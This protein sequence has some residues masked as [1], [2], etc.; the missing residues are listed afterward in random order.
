VKFIAC[1]IAVAFLFSG[2]LATVGSTPQ[3]PETL[4]G[5]VADAGP[6]QTAMVG[7]TVQFDGTGSY[8][9][10]APTLKPQ[11]YAVDI[12]GDGNYLAIG[13]GT[14]VSFFATSSC[15]P[16]WTHDT[17][18][19]VVWVILSEDGSFLATAQNDAPE[20]T[21]SS[22][23]YVS[24]F[25]TSTSQPMWTYQ[26]DYPISVAGRRSLDMTRDGSRIAVGT[27]LRLPSPDY[28][29]K[30]G[31]VY[32]F[33]KDSSTP[34][35]I[36][37]FPKSVMAVRMSGDGNYFA[38][39]SYW[40]E[41]RFYSVTTG[42]LWTKTS[43][44]PFYSV[45]VDYDASYVSAAQGNSK[46]THL[47]RND[48]SLVWTATS[49]G[50]AIGMEMSDDG[51]YF[52]TSE[53]ANGAYRLFG[54]SSPTPAWTYP[55][56]EFV[57]TRADISKDGN[58][59][60]GGSSI[61]T[62]N[63]YLFSKTSG[64]PLLIHPADAGI[65]DVSISY[66]GRCFA[67]ATQGGTLSLFTTEGSP[68]LVWQWT[69]EQPVSGYEL[70]YAWNFGDGATATGTM[71]THA[72]GEPGIYTVMLTVTGHSGDVATD[73]M[74][75]TVLGSV[76]VSISSNDIS[77]SSLEPISGSPVTITANVQG[78][79]GTW[80][81]TVEEALAFSDNFESGTL[82]N[83]VK[84]GWNPCG[85]LEV[86]S[87]VSNS[88]PYSLHCQSNPGTNTGPYVLKYLAG[89]YAHSISK[90]KFYLPAK[91]QA[92]D[93]WDIMR[94]GSSTGTVLGT[95]NYEFYVALR[96][97]DYSID[98]FEYV[99]DASGVWSY[100]CLAMD[101]YE[102][103][104]ETWHDISLE[105]TPAEYI[106]KVGDS[107]V[108]T[109]QR[110]V[111]TLIHH[112]ILGDE[113]GSGGGW[114]NAY[115]D[116]VSVYS[117]TETQTEISGTDASCTVSFYL[118]SVSSANLIGSAENVFVPADSQTPV[119]I[120]WNP[121]AGEHEI[122]VAADNVN[123]PDSDMSNNVAS[124]TI[125]VEDA[126]QVDLS[127]SPGDIF[128]SDEDPVAGAPVTITANVL[129]DWSISSEWVKHGV[130]IDLGGPGE[131]A[132]VGAP[133]VMKQPDGSYTMWYGGVDTWGRIFRAT[134]NDG[135]EWV[136]TGM[137]LDYGG[138]YDKYGAQHPYVILDENGIYNMWYSGTGY[139][140]GYRYYI[141]RAT[142]IDG[143]TWQKQGLELTYGGSYEPDGVYTPCVYFDGSQWHMWY[144]AVAWPSH[145]S[146][147]NHA[148]KTLLSD[149]WIKDGIVLLNTGTYDNPVAVAPRVVPTATGFEMFYVGSD[150]LKYR[151]LHATSP[152]GIAWAKDG[153]VI[154]PTLPLECTKVSVPF[155]INESNTYKMWYTGGGW[156]DENWRIFYAE[157]APGH[158]AQNASCIVSF[159][160]D[161]VVP[162]NLIDSV[163][164]VFVPADGETPVSIEWMPI[165]G[166]H[167][168]IV[169][170]SDVNPPDR[171]LSNNVA[172][173]PVSV[174]EP[175]PAELAVE[176]VKLSGI[177]DGFTHTYY[178]WE[179]QITVSNDGGSAATD[180]V[181]RDVLPAE[182]EMID[183]ISSTG[184][185]ATDISETGGT[186]AA[187]PE[188]VILPERSTRITWIVGTLEPGQSETLYMKVCTRLNPAEK[189]EFTSPGIYILNQGAY[190]TGFDSL[191]G[192]SL[193]SERTSAITVSI[194]DA[195][196]PVRID[197]PSTSPPPPHTISRVK[198]AV[199]INRD[200]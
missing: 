182:L 20:D 110:Q 22:R 178:E 30:V 111:S 153:I 11:I 198:W 62:N 184:M 17:G 73:I 69:T 81:N 109:G 55:Y 26:T 80:T 134:S 145:T 174:A 169:V 187:L 24:F 87:A 160:L 190:A 63:T 163:E 71:P 48:G 38:A 23:G 113:G 89:S 27:A 141:L 149:P 197:P 77:F 57:Y 116:D 122:I 32:I 75:V 15:E 185:A 66:D 102:L 88:A 114:G 176:K 172:S 173:V 106:V 121:V 164:N 37:S 166:E 155:V 199:P 28:L 98:I 183:M 159:Y 1:S 96:D 65:S 165:A 156:I 25:E 29:Q 82:D 103:A 132:H 162:A 150:N 19:R 94:A 200:R 128:I 144:S 126:V 131:D 46:R 130:V 39:G 139:N 56:S 108:A 140:N 93:K 86:S 18:K 8:Y 36:H 180:V 6:D 54:T 161:S 21:W 188:P 138:T 115:W 70:T 44:D 194:E 59:I 112:L 13:W 137:V 186:R 7:E 181:V 157:K 117:V 10:D 35:A 193:E 52:A 84:S 5:L 118:D 158:I 90:I 45:A 83:W 135:I 100:G 154:E 79:I 168:I 14:N 67:S 68:R 191:T 64:T 61:Q 136:K 129:G 72:Y 97:D 179:L 167:E 119:T 146:W 85:I 33:D 171:D 91:T 78:D 147:I 101:V 42:L 49:V 123:P 47:F 53:Y 16:I 104:P 175:L 74:A 152:D 177:D 2:A 50:G 105:I 60:V 127:I 76:D 107:V 99:K 125:A 143:I 192:D 51:Q 41:M 9:S 40:W 142:S 189:Q 31:S 148:H 58:Y 124:L 95:T 196:E 43:S 4:L 3:A 120:E 133:S 151:L 92:F 34:Q 170:I 12:S 195:P